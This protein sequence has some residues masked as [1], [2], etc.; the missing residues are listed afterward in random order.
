MRICTRSSFFNRFVKGMGLCCFF[1]TVM[2]AGSVLG[3][4]LNKKISLSLDSASLEQ[5]IQEIAKKGDLRLSIRERLLSGSTK[6][7]SVPSQL[8][9]T[10]EA[11]SMVLSGTGLRYRV[12]EGYVVIENAP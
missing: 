4:D 9:T 5:S 6:R 11:L 8:L 12:V 1:V 10:G 3:Q 7:V 2:S